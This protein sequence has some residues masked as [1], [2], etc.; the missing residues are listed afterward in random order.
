MTTLV[1]MLIALAFAALVCWLIVRFVNPSTFRNI[2]LG[3][4]VVA[5]VL[6]FLM[7]LFP[8]LRAAG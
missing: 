4:V 7:F 1:P 3:V 6:W 8:A 5:V 2:L